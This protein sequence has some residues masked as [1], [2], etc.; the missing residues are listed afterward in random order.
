[1]RE[2]NTGFRHRQISYV[3]MYKADRDNKITSL[4]FF[5]ECASWLP[6]LWLKKEKEVRNIDKVAALV[7]WGGLP[8][9]EKGTILVLLIVISAT[10]LST[11][12][13]PSSLKFHYPGSVCSS[14]L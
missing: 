6:L 10:S 14:V 9:A 13:Y 1:M 2:T 7:G 3:N 8:S 4:P 11:T 5:A 12:P